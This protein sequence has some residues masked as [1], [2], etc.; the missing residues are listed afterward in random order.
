MPAI[1][2]TQAY[3]AAVKF[4][5][6]Y[7]KTYMKDTSGEGNIGLSKHYRSMEK[8]MTEGEYALKVW[9]KKELL[10]ILK[11]VSNLEKLD[12]SNI[13]KSDI[14]QLTNIIFDAILNA[15][16][17]PETHLNP[18]TQLSKATSL[19]DIETL[20]AE[21]TAAAA[22]ASEREE[23]YDLQL[24]LLDP[25]ILAAAPTSIVPMWRL[26]NYSIFSFK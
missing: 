3:N 16:R 10:S 15:H 26:K 13:S 23:L 19:D 9:D 8:G 21:L 1:T 22:H 2:A 25:E 4:Q 11:K 6:T 20:L 5:K 12:S 24:Q 7:S 17:D 14:K 18:L